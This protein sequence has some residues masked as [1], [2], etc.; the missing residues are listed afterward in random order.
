MKICFSKG[1][2]FFQHSI[3]TGEQRVAHVDYNLK[4]KQLLQ[5]TR[6]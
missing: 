2:H 3:H 1:E 4:G 5:G 6:E